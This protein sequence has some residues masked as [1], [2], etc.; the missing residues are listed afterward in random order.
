[1]YTTV[2]KEDPQN[3][4]SAYSLQY[5]YSILTARPD[6]GDKAKPHSLD[7]YLLKRHMLKYS[8]NNTSVYSSN[9]NIQLNFMTKT[10]H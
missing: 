9:L 1:M 6:E 5:V 3:S 8:E 7:S 10:D 2:I 4:I